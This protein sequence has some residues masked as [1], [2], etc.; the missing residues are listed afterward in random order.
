MILFELS[1]LLYEKDDKKTWSQKETK[2]TI[3][4][5]VGHPFKHIFLS[6]I[7]IGKK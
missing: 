3:N 4:E 5:N 6:N 7:L 2:D 1:M